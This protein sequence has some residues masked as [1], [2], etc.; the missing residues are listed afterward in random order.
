M[1]VRHLLG[2]VD[3]DHRAGEAGLPRA[4]QLTHRGRHVLDIEHR[5]AFEPPRIRATELAEPVVVG[6]EHGAEQVDVGHAKELQPFGRVDH[7]AV[8]AVRLVFL[9]ELSGVVRAAAHLVEARRGSQTI[10]ALEPYA[11]LGA[12]LK[13]VGAHAVDDPPVAVMLGYDARG[14][15]APLRVEPLRPHVGR[16]HDVR[17]RRDQLP[18][19]NGGHALSLVRIA[20]TIAR[21]R[22]R[23]TPASTSMAPLAS[24]AS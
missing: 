19:A 12:A 24:S 23:K 2:W 15:I 9:E 18:V 8:D 17:V 13:R 1:V 5:D 4:L 10:L 20:F 16:L 6:A 3:A 21:T 11:R 7:R 14:A 22:S